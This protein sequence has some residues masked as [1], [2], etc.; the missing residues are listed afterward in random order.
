[1]RLL[2]KAGV[3]A[4]VLALG[5]PGAGAAGVFNSRLADIDHQVLRLE[6]R[7]DDL[8]LDYTQ[9][10]G[11]VGAVEARVRFEEA[12]YQYLV[13]DYEPAALTFYTLVDAQALTSRALTQD[14]EWYL[15][16]CLFE[17][18][19]PATAAEAYQRVVNEGPAHPFF[20][21][22]VRRLL[23]VYG[24]LR[25]NDRFYKTYQDYVVTGRVQTTDFVK[26]T[27]AKSLWRQGEIA[28]S[29]AMFKDI[30][31]ASTSYLKARYFLAVLL[32]QQGNLQDALTEF[33]GVVDA[34]PQGDP[35][36]HRVVELAWLAIGRLSYELGD[37]AT[38]TAA[39]QRLPADSAYY[40]DQLYELVWTYIKQ[41]KWGDALDYLDI[42]LLGFPSHREAVNLEL[43]RA[44]VLMKEG[45]RDEALSSYQSVVEDYTPV[46]KALGLLK[47]NRDDPAR[48][49][50]MLADPSSVESV[51]G[52]PL[53][54]YAVEI[55][56]DDEF[57][58]RAV[59]VYRSMD[60]QQTDLKQSE[61]LADQVGTALRRTDGD[62][63]TFARG[64]SRVR[65]V[66]DDALATKAAV[67]SYEIDYL[68]SRGSSGDRSALQGLSA[69]FSVLQGRTDE[70]D[71][72]AE[73]SQGRRKAWEHQVTAV[74]KVG[75]RVLDATRDQLASARS[76]EALV[77]ENPP[78]VS[79]AELDQV[80][81]DL[82]GVVA[83]LRRSEQALQGITADRTRASLVAM[84]STSSSDPGARD[85]ALLA[86]DYA[87]L[88]DAVRRYR[89][90]VG[91]ADSAGV[92]RHLYDIWSRANSMEQRSAGIM[93]HLDA[94]EGTEMA[95]LRRRLVD[96][97]ARIALSRNELG[98]IQNGAGAIA[99]DIAQDGFGRLEDEIGRT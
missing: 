14:S 15:A 92:F 84:I 74:Q 27:V 33:R 26:Y 17:L 21:D 63:G 89:T 67:V 47:V 85:R 8:D 11:L 20:E 91:A 44:H 3:V 53:P 76:L 71:A 45:R 60:S 75:Q 19:N 73:D 36:D 23:E 51:G 57:M 62:I 81:R 40:A 31:A 1:M 25:D 42:F 80:R 97:A 4:L 82:T 34:T 10:R 94:A 41:E 56:T 18:G 30:Q 48:Y 98:S 50:R 64:R 22:A 55:L 70:V 59:D 61:E 16:E 93:V 99:T 87:Q 43:T 35:S 77:D 7:V 2:C 78:G 66:R 5:E 28:R 49:F 69:R 12:V 58:G 32:T 6:K 9:R 37:Y 86:D 39:Y 65:D 13:G 88:R 46:Q 90:G 96:E 83:D 54:D 38:A 79:G 95:V 68:L 24:L 52:E 29:E 72:K